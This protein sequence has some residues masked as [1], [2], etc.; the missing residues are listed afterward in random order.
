M[1][2]E[3]RGPGQN[4][5]TYLMQSK[6]LIF[7]VYTKYVNVIMTAWLIVSLTV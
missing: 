3:I 2:L 4:N 1:S 5:I 6:E 7:S